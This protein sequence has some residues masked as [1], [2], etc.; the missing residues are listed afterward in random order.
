MLETLRG[1]GVEFDAVHIDRSF[2]EEHRPTRKPG[3]AMLTSYLTGEYDLA[4]SYVIGDRET[5]R[6]LARN[7]GCQALLFCDGLDWKTICETIFLG[8]RT[9]EMR[10]TTRE[11]DI[12]VKM[13]LD[14]TG[15]ADIS[16]GLGFFDHML[17][18]IPHHSDIDLTIQCKGDL[19]VDEHHTIEDT[20]IVLGECLHK[21]LIDKRGIER[22][23]F[24]LPMDDS[25]SS[26]WLDLGGRPWLVW[27]VE[28]RRDC[29]GDFPTEMF[30]HFF[31]SLCDSAKMNLHVN[32]QGTN[33]H[34][35][36]E[37][38]FKAFARAL[39]M[40]IRRD[41]NQARIPSSKGTF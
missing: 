25:R 5:D 3:T 23:G 27:E 16:T 10:R 37:S 7:L 18:Q 1:E 29:I 36:A 22:Y 13:N 32:A 8:E 33:E 9:L 28:F 17:E 21:A 24:Q 39:K 4:G 40:A 6:Q 15:I 41:V 2:P 14:G 19:H 20:A 34:H 30:Y 12:T 11:T 38:I 26:V 31:K 35:K